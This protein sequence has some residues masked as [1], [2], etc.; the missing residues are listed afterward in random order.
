MRI[1]K[2]K[3]EAHPAFRILAGLMSLLA[4]AELLRSDYLIFVKHKAVNWWLVAIVFCGVL[5]FG[6]I[7]FYGR[8]PI[9][10]RHHR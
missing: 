2:S 8:A 5:F 10:R 9:L 4:F 6:Y 7:A 1:L 3:S